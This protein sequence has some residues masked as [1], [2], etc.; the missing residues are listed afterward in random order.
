MKIP[1]SKYQGTGNDFILI[2]DRDRKCP[3][4]NAEHIRTLCDRR[5]GIGADGLILLRSSSC[6]DYTMQFFNPDGSEPGMCGNGLRCFIHFLK[7]LGMHQE[8]YRI[9]VKQRIFTCHFEEE[10]IH[11]VFQNPQVIQWD[12][13]L[14]IEKEKLSVHVV[15]TGVP[16]AVIFDERLEQIDLVQLGRKIRFHP[17]FSP[18]GVNV[19]FAF[20]LPSGEIL[21]RTYERGVEG[22]TLMCGTGAVAVAYAA[23]KK[24]QLRN[25]IQIRAPKN[26]QLEFVISESLHSGCQI[27]MAGPVVQVFTGEVDI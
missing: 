3:I 18:N 7:T 25:P 6:A 2:D 4:Q 5:F 23:F 14:Q 1:F 17:A 26:E 21:M 19:N 9:E 20:I 22:E 8:T 16:H 24:Y 27:E 11:V 13:P 10:R 12:I 15:D